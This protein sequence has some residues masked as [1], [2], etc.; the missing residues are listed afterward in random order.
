MQKYNSKGKI[1][2]L[3]FLIVIFNFLALSGA[4]G[5]IFNLRSA[6]A[7]SVDLGIWPPILQ[8][9]IKPGKSITQ[10]YKVKNFADPVIVT[11]KISAFVPEEEATVNL[12]DCDKIEVIGCESLSWFSFENANLSLNDSFFLTTDRVQDLVL[13]ISV[14]EYVSE[15]DYYNTL[16]FTTLAPPSGSENN[17][18]STAAIASN[19]LITVSKD[20]NPTRDIRITNF[21]AKNQITVFGLPITLSLFD[22]FDQIPVSLKVQNTGTAYTAVKGKI[23]LSGFPGLQSYFTIPPQN[24]LTNN[25]RLLIA[26]PSANLIPNTKYE[27]QNTLLLPHGFY[28]GRYTLTAEVET[29]EGQIKKATIH[30]FAAPVK[31]IL[32]FLG[33]FIFLILIK[34]LIK[35]YRRK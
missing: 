34:K 23:K 9:M 15:G 25:T 32:V 13:K 7:Q 35:K 20:G 31:F 18:K 29:S 11:S 21:T 10:V 1:L 22:S 4:N 8:V 17:V 19:I 3:S 33:L 6:N 27:I 2:L 14:P 16:L 28:L 12:I 24:I 30:F 5:L 26:T